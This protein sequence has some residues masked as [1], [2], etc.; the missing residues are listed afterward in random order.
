MG[1]TPEE[2]VKQFSKTVEQRDWGALREMLTDD[3]VDHEPPSVSDEPLGSE[4]MIE[5]IKPF[6]WRIDVK[7]IVSDGN[8][9]VTRE[10]MHGT[11]IEAFQGLPPSDKAVSTSTI[12]IW[13]IEDGKIAEMWQSPDT[14]DFIDQL[15][16]TFPEILLTMPK[17]L[18]TKLRP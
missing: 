16:A 3:F 4:E 7:D 9:V 15:G 13:R 5:A 6:E 12:I 2:V 17:M 1:G 18:V 11:Q 14:H 8:K 10:V